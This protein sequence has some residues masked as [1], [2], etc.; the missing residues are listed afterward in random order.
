MP[1]HSEIGSVKIYSPADR[2]RPWRVS[3]TPPGMTRQV[4]DR[5]TKDE[6][7]AL[8]KE[9]KGQ[10]KRGEIGRVHRVT[11]EE[12]Q[13]LELCRKLRNPREILEEALQ[14]QDNFKRAT[15][16]ACCDR[17]IEEYRDR[18]SSMTRNDATSKAGV[19]RE[20][21]GERYLDSL[22]ERDIEEWRDTKL[23][24]SNR[25]RNNIHAHL[26][27][28]FERARVWGYIPKGHNPAREV[29]SLKIPKAEPVVWSPKTLSECLEWYRD[30]EKADAGAKIVFLA[31]GAF[32]G[33]RPSEIEGVVGERD[34]LQ[35][36]DI[37]FKQRHIRVRAEV[38]GKLSEPR[39]ITFTEKKGSGLTKELADTM[40]DTLVSWIEPHRKS[41][42]SVCF[43]KCQRLVSPE[44]RE[45][46]L[47]TNWPND[48]LRH[49]W[50]SSLLAL[51]VSRD[52]VAEMAGNSPGIIRTNYKRP[53]P[54]KIALSWFKAKSSV[55]A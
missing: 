31:L 24:G 38:A 42:G 7:I 29:S 19:I 35:W 49:T 13:L 8:A 5:K 1:F 33:M 30:S 55:P 23:K 14:R 43:R 34:G 54:E 10:L 9:I 20:T 51:G 45:A 18:D 11:T 37:D 41:S 16:A 12:S 25:Y 39:Y 50:I 44:L 15:V 22:T 27:H 28:L 4:K 52:W 36:D 17:Y 2:G 32:A 40:W 46:D 21:L 47:I 26:R 3:W 6:A 53:L 48:G